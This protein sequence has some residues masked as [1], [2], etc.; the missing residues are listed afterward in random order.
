MEHDLRIHRDYVG[1]RRVRG[2]A[3]MARYQDQGQ[4]FHG[5]TAACSEVDSDPDELADQDDQLF[6]EV[7]L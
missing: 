1:Y 6:A 2:D 7:G 3:R 4:D 5:R